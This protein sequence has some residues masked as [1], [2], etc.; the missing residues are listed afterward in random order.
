MIITIKK[1]GKGVD[2]DSETASLHGLE[3]VNNWRGLGGGEGII[4]DKNGIIGR[5]FG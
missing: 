5:G 1:G 2:G 3:L 4:M